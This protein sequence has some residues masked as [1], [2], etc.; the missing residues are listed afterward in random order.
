MMTLDELKQ[1]AGSVGERQGWDFSRARDARDPVPW[2]YDE[3]VLRYLKATDQVLDI[4]TGGGEVFLSFAHQ[5][6][7]GIGADF[8]QGMVDVAR[9]NAADKGIT[10]VAFEV[11]ADHDLRVADESCDVVLNRHSSVHPSEVMR[12]LR[13]GGYFISQQVAERNT[14]NIHAAFGWSW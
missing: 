6:A 9:K 12:V 5:F 2:H 4:G 7:S 11:M 3:V 10:N 8:D 14:A 13:P 1:I